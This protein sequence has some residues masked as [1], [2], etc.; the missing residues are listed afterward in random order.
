MYVCMYV[1]IYIYSKL[2]NIE[3]MLL[4]L[5]G[6]HWHSS[7]SQMHSLLEKTWIL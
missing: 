4:F 6:Y 5:K 1:C 2:C 7:F 3:A